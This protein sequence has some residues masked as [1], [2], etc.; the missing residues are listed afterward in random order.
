ML[1][2]ADAR[3]ETTCDRLRNGNWAWGGSRDCLHLA[4]GFAGRAHANPSLVLVCGRLDVAA[5]ERLAILLTRVDDDTKSPWHRVKEE[6]KQ[7]T[8]QNNR[9][10]LDH[11]SWLREQAIGPSTFRDIPEVKLKQFAAEAIFI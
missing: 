11:L 2:G 8:T 7:P 3:H 4:S 5:R 6:P 10:F 1:V 9:E